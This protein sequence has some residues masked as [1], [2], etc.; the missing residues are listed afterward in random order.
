MV[1]TGNQG[2]S[3]YQSLAT[4]GSYKYFTGTAGVYL[5]PNGLWAAVL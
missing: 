3:P 5:F 4:L 2:I 1:L